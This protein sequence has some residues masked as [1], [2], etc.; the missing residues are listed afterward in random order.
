MIKFD[1]QYHL[2]D[3]TPLEN[4]FI[5]QYLVKSPGDFIKV[6]IYCLNSSYFPQDYDVTYESIA[7]ALKLTPEEVRR[8]FRYWSR[9]GVMTVDEYD[10]DLVDIE[11]HSMKDLFFSGSSEDNAQL[12]KYAE[13]NNML[14]E[15]FAPR[16]LDTQDY[17]LY[18]DIL[19]CFDVSEEYVIEAVKYS[20]R[21]TKS[22]DVPY[23]YVEKVVEGWLNEGL[24]DVNSVRKYL[25][26]R[27]ATYKELCSILKYLGMG[28]R[29]PTVPELNC[30][31]KWREEWGFSFEAIKQACESTLGANNPSIKYLDTILQGLYEEH[32][33]QPEK[34]SAEKRAQDSQRSRLRKLLYYLG[35]PGS[36]TAV[37]MQKY[38]K[39]END[40]GFNDEAI[41][42]A[43]SMI[44]DSSNTFEALDHLLES[45]YINGI[46]NADSMIA[47]M[48]EK[49]MFDE[50]VKQVMRAFHTVSAISENERA[51]LKHWKGDLK[52]NQDLIL[53]GASLALTAEKRWP[54]LNKILERWSD[55]GIETVAAAKE[56][57]ARIQSS[58]QGQAS[59]SPS[60][61]K[62]ASF[63]NI[64]THNYTKQDYDEM[65]SNLGGFDD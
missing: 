19:S 34:I 49:H 6:Y 16:I 9:L 27:D 24:T 41:T 53:Y 35:I 56:D 12:Y 3:V 59:A 1:G 43:A 52:M 57:T 7:N 45:F 44:T 28:G 51:Y 29:A 32:T 65:M 39:W 23:K 25:E 37:H 61:L 4:L 48:N 17:I 60:K 50:D 15:A 40:Y 54:Y 11:L 58:E 64:D 38:A 55:A 46:S 10:D 47:Y 36:P 26:K 31:K 8:A 30:Y 33:L 63:I 13:F 14:S 21:T 42:I 5:Q 20:I 22:I 62:G 2:Y 18:Q